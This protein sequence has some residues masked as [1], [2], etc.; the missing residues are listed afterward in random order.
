MTLL[1]ETPNSA[2]AVVAYKGYKPAYQEL[3]S[4]HKWTQENHSDP[5][6]WNH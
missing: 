5:H 3:I 6:Q 2:K 4:P 1:Q